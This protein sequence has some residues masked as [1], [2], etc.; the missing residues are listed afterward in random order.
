MHGQQEQAVPRLPFRETAAPAHR[1]VFRCSPEAM[2][3]VPHTAAR[4]HDPRGPGYNAHAADPASPS[5]TGRGE[6]G[7]RRPFSRWKALHLPRRP[8]P[9]RDSMNIE[10]GSLCPRSTLRERGSG[11]TRSRACP[12][13]GVGTAQGRHRSWRT[14][15]PAPMP[16][17]A[18]APTSL[19]SRNS[20][21]PVPPFG[22]IPR[23]S[24]FALRARRRAAPPFQV[25]GL[26]PTPSASHR[27]A[28]GPYS[29]DSV[30]L[31]C[32]MPDAFHPELRSMALT[33]A[34]HQNS[35]RLPLL[36]ARARLRCALRSS[37]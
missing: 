15:V 24:P 3:Q 19:L 31:D 14:A 32:L 23:P 26:P 21:S 7:H 5:C 30:E 35:D 20:S 28:R 12:T 10:S 37:C 17:P 13:S 27:L 36:A 1:Y 4:L 33:V 9:I 25:P 16:P 34:G 11:S 22:L 18:L 6:P 2:G 8:G 29:H